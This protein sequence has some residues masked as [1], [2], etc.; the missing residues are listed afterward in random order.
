LHFV[1]GE[2][3]KPSLQG[4]A[5]VRFSATHSGDL[6]MIAVA[7]V[8]VGIDAELVNGKYP[9][10]YLRSWVHQEAWAKATGRGIASASSPTSPDWSYQELDAGARAVAGL[11]VHAAAFRVH[12]RALG[13]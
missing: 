12:H 7:E 4:D 3:G 2:Y 8:E 5:G 10:S 9:H 11:F 6:L 1:Y 13:W